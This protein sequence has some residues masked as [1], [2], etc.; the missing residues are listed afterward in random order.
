METK[1]DNL[2]DLKFQ[3]DFKICMEQYAK[4]FFLLHISAIEPEEISKE[5]V[6]FIT[7]P[8]NVS[9]LKNDLTKLK[10]NCRE[11]LSENGIT[12]K[13]VLMPFGTKLEI[14]EPE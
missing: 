9:V 1:M 10:N 8:E 4:D 6:L 12:N 7:L 14:K 11:V 13:I 3:R 5:A 2:I